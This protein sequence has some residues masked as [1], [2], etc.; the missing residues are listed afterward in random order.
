MWFEALHQRIKRFA[1]NSG[2]KNP[3]LTIATKFQERQAWNLKNGGE[4][5]LRD[6]VSAEFKKK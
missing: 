3:G 5:Y 6:P 2:F 1:K 4:S